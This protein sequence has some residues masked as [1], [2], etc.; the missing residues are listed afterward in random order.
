MPDVFFSQII[1]MIILAFLVILGMPHF[2][3]PTD[4]FL[5]TSDSVDMGLGAIVNKEEE[6]GKFRVPTLRN[7]AL[8]A[9]YGHNGYFQTLEEIVHFYNVRDVSDEFP[10]AECP[11]TVNRDEL[12]NLGLTP[13]EEADLIAFMKTL[14]DD[15]KSVQK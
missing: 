15:F 12:G 9:P 8:T 2:H 10:P 3:V 14:T 5:L 13:K 11:A 7:I 4:Y 1:L 6:N